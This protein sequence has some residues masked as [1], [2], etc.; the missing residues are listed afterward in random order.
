MLGFG[1]VRFPYRRFP[2]ASHHALIRYRP[3]PPSLSRVGHMSTTSPIHPVET[4]QRRSETALDKPH[5]DIDITKN[6]GTQKV[7]E[8]KPKEQSG[9][10]Y[11]LEVRLYIS[12]TYPTIPD[13]YD[14]RFLQL[15]PKPAFFDHRIQMFEQLKAEYDGWV[16]GKYSKIARGMHFVT[17][18]Q[19]NPGKRL[20]SPCRMAL[21]RKGRVGRQVPWISPRKSQKVSLSGSSSQ[22]S[23]VNCG[24]LNDR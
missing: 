7:K 2:A 12:F 21:K 15:S 13:T 1:R 20:S 16:K 19:V 17:V 24:I 10:A 14:L 3:P 8:K 18:P 23:T 22:K 5:A 6:G 4:T 11:P 9:S